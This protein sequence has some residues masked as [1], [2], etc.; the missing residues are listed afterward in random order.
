ML[1]SKKEEQSFNSFLNGQKERQTIGQ[2]EI[3]TQTVRVQDI[4]KSKDIDT[5]SLRDRQVVGKTDSER[6]RETDRQ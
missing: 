6:L 2:T 5:D 1:L 4:D 3:Q